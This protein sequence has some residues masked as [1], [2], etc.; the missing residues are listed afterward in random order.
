MDKPIKRTCFTAIIS[1]VSR[2][3]ALYTHP[4]CPCPMSSFFFLRFVRVGV[5]HSTQISFS[6]KPYPLNQQLNQPLNRSTAQ[7]TAQPTNSTNT[8]THR[9]NHDLTMACQTLHIQFQ[10]RCS[11]S[12]T[13]A[14]CRH[15]TLMWTGRKCHSDFVLT[16]RLT[17][18]SKT[19]FLCRLRRSPCRFQLPAFVDVSEEP[20]LEYCP[21]PKRDE[22]T[23]PA[24][25]VT[26]A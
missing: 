25:W 19:L 5:I 8:H 1:P 6:S 10:Q 3:W 24:C 4:N 2:F 7:P 20:V 17:N 16:L 14:N 22:I 18:L 21:P 13:N 15:L 9:H 23:L 11:I 26:S 12:P